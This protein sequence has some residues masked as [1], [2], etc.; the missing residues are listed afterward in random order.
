MAAVTRFPYQDAQLT[1]DQRVDDL[2]A[3]M[4]LE[5]K[6]GLLFHA[7][8]FAGDVD[9]SSNQMFSWLPPR[10]LIGEFGLTHISVFGSLPDGRSFA[11]GTTWCSGSRW[12]TR[13]RC[14]SRSRPTRGTTSPTT[15][16]RRRWRARSRSGPSHRP[17]RHRLRGAGAR[18]RRHRPTGIPRRRAAHRAPPPDRSRHRAAV[19]TDPVD[20][21]RGRRARSRLVVAYI[22]ASR[23]TSSAPSRWRR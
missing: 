8:T 18:V 6:A 12:S 21:R 1:V 9:E 7:M 10:R 15:R 3:R 16:S 5:D 4:S 13:S 22:A 2:L 17:R 20:V 14:P 19:D 23:P 11:S